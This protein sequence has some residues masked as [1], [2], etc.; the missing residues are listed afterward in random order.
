MNQVSINRSHSSH[1]SSVVLIV[2]D[3]HNIGSTGAT[4]PLSIQCALVPIAGAFLQLW[5]A[6]CSVHLLL[7]AAVY[8]LQFRS[9]SPL[10][11]AQ[12]GANHPQARLRSCATTRAGIRRSQVSGLKSI[13]GT[14]LLITIIHPSTPP[15]NQFKCRHHRSTTRLCS[16]RHRR[17]PHPPLPSSP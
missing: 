17:H 2:C 12:S 8:R 7:P 15:G 13:R 14:L 11:T 16:L 1:S 3:C 10:W 6:L 4:V 5:T 9:G